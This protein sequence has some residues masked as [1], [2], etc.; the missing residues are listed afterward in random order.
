[1]R[2]PGAGGD[3]S[4]SPSGLEDGKVLM[5]GGV[6]VTWLSAPPL[7]RGAGEKKLRLPSFLLK[8]SPATAEGWRW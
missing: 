4:P 5:V 3:P 2:W 8:I 1:M 7:H 6:K